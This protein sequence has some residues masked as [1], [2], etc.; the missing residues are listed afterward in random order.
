MLGDVDEPAQ[1]PPF[2]SVRGR[3]SV[4]KSEFLS[5]DPGP[6]D[7]LV[8]VAGGEPAHQSGPRLLAVVVIAAA[9]QPAN[10]E[11]RV[12]GVPLVAKGLLLDSAAD[13][14]EGVQAEADHM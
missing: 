4:E 7:L 11:Q 3:L 12:A 13:L 9:Q 8:V 14:V 6:A 1:Q 10:P 2:G 5:G